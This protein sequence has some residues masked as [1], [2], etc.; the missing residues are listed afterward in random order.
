MKFGIKITNY[1]IKKI[2][3]KSGGDIFEKCLDLC[4]I[5]PVVPC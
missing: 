4:C 3:K 5:S 2:H 1:L